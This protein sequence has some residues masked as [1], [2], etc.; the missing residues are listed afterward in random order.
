MPY[1]IYRWVF[2][3]RFCGSNATAAYV[4]ICDNLDYAY[5]QGCERAHVVCIVDDFGDLVLQPS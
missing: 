1:T 4:L 2:S 5:M 3:G